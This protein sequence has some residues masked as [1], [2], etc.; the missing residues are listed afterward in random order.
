MI[1][2]QTLEKIALDTYSN[3]KNKFRALHTK[4]EELTGRYE[5][6]LRANSITAD[7]E[8]KVVLGG[9]FALVENAIPRLLARQPKYRYLARGR[10]D[11]EASELYDEFSDYQWSESDAQNTLKSIVKWALICGL[12]GWKMGWKEEQKVTSRNGKEILGIK[13]T[14]PAIAGLAEK[15][16]VGK[17]VKVDEAEIISNYTLE[18]VKPSDLI[19][20]VEA[21]GPKDARVLGYKTRKLIKE[22]KQLGYD[23]RSLVQTVKDTDQFRTNMEQRDGMTP[24][25]VNR[26]V[27]MEEVEVA[28]L[29]IRV[30][31]DS[32]YFEFHCVT[33]VT[34]GD[35]QAIVLAVEK[36]PFDKQFFTTGVFRPIERPGK[37]YGFGL[38]EPSTGVL[39]AEEDTL[40]MAMEAFWTDIC[41]PM[42]YV[43]N[44]ILD[45][46]A[47]E[48]RPR[49]LVPVRTLGQS[50]L[51][52]AT[53]QF[54]ANTLQFFQDYLQRSKQNISA[55]TDFQTGAEQAQGGK[56]LG[57]IQIK[58]E[59]SNARLK[60]IVDA[61][62]KEIIE[63]I[64]KNALYMNQQFL[65]ENP[66]IIYRVLG[67]KGS[68]NEK[69]IKFKDIE[70]IKDV[71]VISGSSTLVAQQAEIQKWTLLLNQAYLEEKEPNPVPINKESIWERLLET[72]L[73]IKDVEK[74]LPAAK[75]RE[76]AS[77]KNKTKDMAHAKEENANPMIARVLPTDTPDVHVP[78]HQ[79][80]AKAR[81]AEVDSI[82]QQGG[83]PPD[84]KKIGR[85][86]CRERVCQYV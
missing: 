8:S 49:T 50:V 79:A 55:I 3:H 44:N 25:S 24:Y 18:D 78:L 73:L 2:K 72:G 4:F 19:W 6:A 66:K 14:N 38:I 47:L 11:S 67:R 39:D 82:Q 77:A 29:E 71:M 12:S 46:K 42:E 64:G 59:E 10:E 34:Y 31:N 76:E 40:N 15:I 58:T 26:V 86:S 28:P 37:F 21:L 41:K 60:M 16:G 68:I 54:N 48:Y 53:P 35:T 20:N 27:E 80:E 1:S 30:L 5:N 81:E 45:I 57:E 65:V 70:A 85:A 63:P 61:M 9:A 84:R 43:P 33:L 17:N 22:L 32:G 51:P 56:T 7:T 74:F 69:P 13:Y 36:N 62:E 23:T 52:M 75:E 83:Q